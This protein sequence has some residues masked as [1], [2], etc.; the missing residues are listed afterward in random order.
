MA[1][2]T[3]FCFF[4]EEGVKKGGKKCIKC[5]RLLPEESFSKRGGE[6]YLRT[7]CKECNR[8]LSRERKELKDKHGAAP[9]NHRCP[10]CK[11]SEEQCRGEGS[12]VASAFVLDHNHDT[13]NFRGWLCHKGNRQIGGDNAIQRLRESINYL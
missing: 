10:I 8:K 2:Q 5:L 1:K 12:K 13:G 6:N 3:T 11:R 9:K 4:E 7:E